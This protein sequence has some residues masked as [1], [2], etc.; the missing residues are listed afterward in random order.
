MSTARRDI[1]VEI[2][3]AAQKDWEEK[4]LNEWDAPAAPAEGEMDPPKFFT[5]FPFPYMNGMLHLGHA[6]SFTKSEF[7]SRYERMMGKRS[8]WAFAFHA[9]GMP[10][11]ACANKISKEMATYGNPPQFP[12][13]DNGDTPLPA[14][15]QENA[16]QGTFKSKRGKSGPA[17]PQWCIM[18]QMGVPDEEI[19]KFA[20]PIHWLE[21]FPPHALK[22]LKRFGCHIDYRRSFITTERSPYFDRFVK[23]QF[24]H[25][26]EQKKLN[27]GKRHCIYSPLD[28]QPCADHD[29]ACGEGIQLQEYAI[30]KLI[31][32]N[33]KEQ[34]ALARF[35]HIIDAKPVIIACATLRVET[36]VGQTNCWVSPTI[37]YK[38]YSVQNSNGGEEIFLMTGRAAR[39]MAYQGFTINGVTNCDPTPLFELQGSELI[40]L[41]ISA[42][43]SVYKTIYC[44]PMPTILESKGT[45]CVMSVPSDSPDDYINF[46]QLAKK[47]DYRAKLHIKDEWVL[48]FELVPI[49]DIPELGT[50]AAKT[51]CE[52][53]KING[54]NAKDLLEEAKKVVYQKGFY[55]GKMICGPLKGEKVLAAKSKCQA[56]LEAS[57]EA[58]RYY[59]PNGLVVSRSGD[60]CVVALQNQWYLEYGKNE[61]WKQAVIAHLKNVQTFS[62][63]VRNGFEET[64]NWL[65]EW[66]C[67]RTFGLGTYIPSDETHTHLIDSLSDST[68]Y[69]AYYTIA[70]Y[71]HVDENGQLRLF[72][73]CSNTHGLKPEMFTRQTFD[74]IFL[75]IGEASEVAAAVGMLEDILREMRRE[76]TY[77]YPVD[78]RCS[79]KDLIQN[80]LTMFLYN[81]AA[82]WPDDQS[83][84]PR[85]IFCN[86]HVQVD[87][88]KMA[89]SKGNF[90]TLR[91]AV[92]T[93]GADATRLACAD[94]GDTLDD[95]NFVRETASG[96]VLKLTTVLQQAEEQLGST[97]LRTGE[98]WRLDRMFNNTMNTL[99]ER[100]K[101]YYENM[102]FRLVLNSAYHELTSEYSLYKQ[103][104]SNDVHA[105]MVHRYYEVLSLLLTPL[106]PHFAEHMW[107]KIL[108]KEGNAVSQSFP[109]PDAPVN[110]SLTVSHRIIKDTTKE[111]RAQFLKITKKRPEVDTAVVYVATEYAEWQRKALILLRNIF[112]ENGHSVPANVSNIVLKTKPVWITKQL[113]PEI[114]AFLNFM[115]TQTENCG[116]DALS[117][118]PVVNDY[119]LL[120]EMGS[121]LAKF[122]GVKEVVIHRSSDTTYDEHRVA[123]MKSRPG[124]PSVAFLPG[125]ASEKKDAKPK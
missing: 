87:N 32:Q 51:I 46:S 44:L 77:W 43:L 107:Q 83:K 96:F 45:G 61:M 115:R 35:A 85:G 99:I 47:P 120:T 92:E 28:G 114:M 2:E 89:K 55:S 58:I 11:A 108:K 84:W 33:P 73:D 6:Y 15:A 14:S 3:L 86:G 20:D 109:V 19:S 54:P 23:W 7:T 68:I 10:I 34:E 123:R 48:P 76:F 116:V 5:T 37:V 63:A 30:V 93:Y 53:M 88:E 113:M 90:I 49:I 78:L 79:G 38:A 66:A 106:A 98:L 102:Q 124:E 74:Y 100:T 12:I 17:K 122:S 69:M 57:G 111:I 18:Q 25:L 59:E 39:N 125:A 26:Y 101:S 50:E 70:K 67:S 4:K 29:R 56:M 75:G 91:E 103:Y 22:D 60:E 95:A 112:E 8:L 110:F 118:E 9:T 40:G 117:L 24:D 105:E 72:G 27:Y 94:A 121:S 119:D 62:A 65:Q 41:P 16:P 1:L 21:Y 64:L 81:H 31:V 82:I 97:S 52:T 36:V 13:D 104:V 80:H 71:M 42:P